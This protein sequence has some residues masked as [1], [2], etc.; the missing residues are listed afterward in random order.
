LVRT[1]RRP[2]AEEVLREWADRGD[3]PSAWQL[4]TM[5]ADRNAVDELTRRADEG[6]Q[7]MSW[8]L[9]ELL[10]RRDQ[11]RGLVGRINAGDQHAGDLLPVVLTKAGRYDEALRVRRLGLD[12]DGS[13]AR[14]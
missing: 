9:A 10:A 14:Q 8:H 13:V 3:Q 11:T 4:A 6:D 5:L 12:A 1:G 7:S 2:A